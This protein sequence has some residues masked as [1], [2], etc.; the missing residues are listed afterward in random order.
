M[1]YRVG[2]SDGRIEY[3]DTHGDA[4]ALI[5]ARYGE[6][7]IGH[8]GDI[9]SGGDRTLAWLTD[10]DADGDDGRRACAVIHS[11]EANQ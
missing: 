4:C 10:E 5:E 11:E 6:V 8:P 7:I 1:G 9:P 3:A 2:H